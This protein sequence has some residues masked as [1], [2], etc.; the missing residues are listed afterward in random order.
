MS[1]L[2]IKFRNSLRLVGLLSLLIVLVT[3]SLGFPVRAAET[4]HGYLQTFQSWGF[5]DG[6][7]AYG[8][9]Q[10]NATSVGDLNGDGIDDVAIG[11]YMY[12]TKTGVVHLYSGSNPDGL[13]TT[14]KI[15]GYTNY[16]FGYNLLVEDLNGDGI[17]D[18]IVCAINAPSSVTGR[19]YIYFGKSDFF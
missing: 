9:S 3:I 10:S 1:C 2:F 13:Q 17:D 12:A 7:G 4:V 8:A 6:I 14:G 15:Y 11:Q 16:W 18:L 5:P 19:L